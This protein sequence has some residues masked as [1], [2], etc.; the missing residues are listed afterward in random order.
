MPVTLVAEAINSL[1]ETPIYTVCA[2]PI[3][4]TFQLRRKTAASFEEKPWGSVAAC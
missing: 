3:H 2:L 1:A 4:Q